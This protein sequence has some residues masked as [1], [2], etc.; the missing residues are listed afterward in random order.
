MQVSLYRPFLKMQS[1][2][3][4]QALRNSTYIFWGHTTQFLTLDFRKDFTYH[5]IYLQD[6]ARNVFFIFLF[7]YNFSED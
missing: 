6:N 2:F 7:S 5:C 4:V 3:E 1:H